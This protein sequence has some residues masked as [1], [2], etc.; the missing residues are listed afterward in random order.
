MAGPLPYLI[1]RPS[2]I[3]GPDRAEFRPGERLGARVSDALL[4][5]AR[6]MGARRLWA[7]YRSTTAAVLAGA[8]VRS[9]GDPRTNRILESEELREE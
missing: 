8:L 7:H 2:F 1:A 6:L 5:L 3:T 4:G 9:A